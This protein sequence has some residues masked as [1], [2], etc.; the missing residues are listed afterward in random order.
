[1]A[2]ST[3]SCVQR[4]GVVL[5]DD[6]IHVGELV[7]RVAQRGLVGG[8]LGRDLL[9]DQRAE[10]GAG[11]QEQSDG[12]ECAAG[13]GGHRLGIPRSESGKDAA[14]RDKRPVCPSQNPIQTLDEYTTGPVSAVAA[15][16]ALPCA[17]DFV[18]RQTGSALAGATDRIGPPDIELPPERVKVL[19]G[20]PL[21]GPE[22]RGRFGQIAGKRAMEARETF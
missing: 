17:A 19:R 22:E 6:R 8:G 10:E 14:R 20:Q 2:L 21:D 7:Q 9:V 16:A 4:L 3:L 15:P 5:L 12:E 11:C 18:S 13:A 1:M